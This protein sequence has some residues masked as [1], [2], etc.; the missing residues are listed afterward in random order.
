MLFGIITTGVPLLLGTV[1][2]LSFGYRLT[3]AVGGRFTSSITY[4]PWM[5]N[6]GRAWG[7]SLR[8]LWMG[9]SET[10]PRGHPLLR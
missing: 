8:M 4:T 2:G 1:V 10:C 3:A 5:S 6:R 7:Q 9:V